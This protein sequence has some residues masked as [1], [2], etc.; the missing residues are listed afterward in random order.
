MMPSDIKRKLREAIRRY[1]TDWRSDVKEVAKYQIDTITKQ[2][3]EE[4]A[5]VK[6]FEGYK[7]SK[8]TKNSLMKFIDS[9]VGNIA[10]KIEDEFNESDHPRD[11][12]G[13]F[14]S[15]GGEGS[16][17][18]SKKTKANESP[19]EETEFEKSAKEELNGKKGNVVTTSMEFTGDKKD[20]EQLAKKYGFDYKLKYP[21]GSP[22]AIIEITGDKDAL[23]KYA[24]SEGFGSEE[25]AREFVPELFE[26]PE[27]DDEGYMGVS[28]EELAEEEEYENARERA[29]REKDN[30]RVTGPEDRDYMTEEDDDDGMYYGPD[31]DK[32]KEYATDKL[33]EY[34]VGDPKF[35]SKSTIKYR[36]NGTQSISIPLD[37]FGR[38]LHVT[39][40]PKS[41]SIRVEYYAGVES[42]TTK[43]EGYGHREMAQALDKALQRID[44]RNADEREYWESK[45]KEAG[46]APKPR[47]F[48]E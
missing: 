27:D 20:A 31:L 40:D 10:R 44:A 11:K 13:R 9:C 22:Y 15:K 7:D 38:V 46:P 5:T 14:T 1:R 34:G 12:G 23:R 21:K 3:P 29:R 24:V 19:V 16:G 18:A 48:Y 32:I 4:A 26:D 41:N 2:Y 28:K 25:D 37:Q 8:M 30:D 47:S 17:G 45:N 42:F 36:E 43:L 33:K 39:A 35:T 6:R